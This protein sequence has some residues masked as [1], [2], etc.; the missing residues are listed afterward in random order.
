M[1]NKYH[2]RIIEKKWQKY[3]Q[4]NKIF[5]TKEKNSQKKFYCLDMFPYPSGAGLHVGHPEGYTATDIICRYRRMK[6]G[7]NILH[8]MGFDAFGLPAENYAIKVGRNPKEIT[9]ENIKRFTKQLKSFGFSYDWERQVITSE[10]AY[11]KWTQWLFGEFYK[12]GLAYKK[13]APVNWCNSCKTVL[14]REQVVDGKCERC[15][16][17]VIQKNLSQWFFKITDYAEELLTDIEKLD[18]PASI[19]ALQRNWI[20]KSVGAEIKFGIKDNQE[21]LIVFTTRPDTLF[22]ATFMVVAPE[23]PLIKKYKLKIINYKKIEEYVEQARKKNELERTDLNKDKTGI[24]IKGIKAVNPV[25]GKE[26]PI[27]VADYVMMGYGTGAI[28]AVPAHDERDWEFAKKYNL[29]IIEVIKG[30][31]INKKAFTE[32]DSGK[33]INSDF[34]NGLRPKEAIKKMLVW[35]EENNLGKRTVQYKLRDWLISRQ[36]Y[37]GAPIPI[38]YCEHCASHKPN[39]LLIHGTGGDGRKNWFGWLADNLR[40]Q[41]YGVMAPDLP[42]ADKPVLK[43]WLAELDRYKDQINENSIIV[44]HSLGGPTA[45][46]FISNLKRKIGKL[47]LVAPTGRG[48][49][50]EAYAK[51]HPDKPVINIKNFS[52]I[53]IDFNEINKNVQEI[54]YYYSDNDVHIQPAINDYYKKNLKANFRLKRGYNHFSIKTSGLDKFPDLLE[55]ILRTGRGEHLVPLEDLPVELPDD[56]DFH[57]TGESPLVYSKSF[58]KVRCPVCGATEGVRREVDTMDTFVCSSWYFLRYCDNKNKQAAFNKKKIDYWMPVDLYV[59]GAEH[60]VLHLM[61]AR[62]FTKAL[63]DMGY[64]NIKSRE[65]FTKLRNQ[66][67]ILA[68]DGRKMSKSLGNV[69]NPDEVVDEYGADTFRMYEMF[70][71]PLEDTKPWKT[72]SIIGIRRFLEK[73]WRLQNKI[74]ASYVIDFNINKL[75][76]QTIQQVPD[77]IEG[78]RFNTAISQLM[79][80]INSLD[81]EKKINQ[82][83]FEQFLVLLSPFAPHITEELWEKLGYKKSIIFA[84][85]P[86]YNKNLIQENEI[87]LVVQVNGKVR[88]KIKVAAD[89]SEQIAKQKVL[90]SEK[91]QKWLKSA[92]IKKII[93]IKNKLISLVI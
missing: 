57:P 9:K 35:L 46:E 47:I 55:E 22:G 52:E 93:Y 12:H 39:I 30:G 63:C 77:D 23:H 78:M 43:D 80:L 60:A 76:H 66:G 27:W 48:A 33:I 7:E 73:V 37:W 51:Q 6:Y 91:I 61:Y 38:I 79:I 13:E 4:E 67:M 17:E 90:E 11:Y 16:N 82:K 44:A 45:L 59:G 21:K 3:W 84:N 72:S 26:I 83:L 49:D 85:W 70:M 18:W 74:I 75:L 92:K 31:D 69:I 1:I 68:E 25:N 20:G 53:K 62:F 28:M 71:G 65:P 88:D 42:R 81:K 40:Q 58:H 54:V 32:I 50:W 15:K 41:G 86:E 19:K 8:P 36:R 34:I 10:P 24:E 29:E 64:I 14:A 2:H 5:K 87:E 56:V 89:I